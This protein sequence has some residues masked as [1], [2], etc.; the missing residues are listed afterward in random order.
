MSLQ[1]WSS[2]FYL[3]RC[4]FLLSSGLL[5]AFSLFAQTFTNLHNF[6]GGYD[7]ANPTAPQICSRCLCLTF[8]CSDS[9]PS[10]VST[11]VPATEGSRLFGR[12]PECHV[13]VHAYC[14]GSLSRDS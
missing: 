1:N 10:V 6:T 14:F 11:F 8:C 4:M 13:S 9:L 2:S 3:R 12:S 7:E 5:S